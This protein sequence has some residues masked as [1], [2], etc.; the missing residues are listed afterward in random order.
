MR[1][2]TECCQRALGCELIIACRCLISCRHEARVSDMICGKLLVW[3]CF[4][5]MKFIVQ[6]EQFGRWWPL[7]LMCLI[8]QIY[9]F[10]R[11]LFTVLCWVFFFVIIN[12]VVSVYRF[13]ICRGSCK[14]H[15]LLDVL[16][17]DVMKKL[18]Q[19]TLSSSAFRSASIWTSKWRRKVSRV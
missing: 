1:L 5:T 2:G 7:P 11:H 14:L 8:K 6:C 16:A 12:T 10:K 4:Y 15:I 19:T 13:T 9:L 17:F 3:F 18:D